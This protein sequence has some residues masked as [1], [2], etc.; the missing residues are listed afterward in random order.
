MQ[1]VGHS[2]R[3]VPSPQSAASSKT[4]RGALLTGVVTLFWTLLLLKEAQRR[5]RR[6]LPANKL[7]IRK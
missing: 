3:L 4:A 5:E 1:S 2:K 7:P 6:T